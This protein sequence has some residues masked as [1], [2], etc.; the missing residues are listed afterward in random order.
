MN[1]VLSFRDKLLL[2]MPEEVDF[3]LNFGICLPVPPKESGELFLSPKIAIF[4]K[5]RLGR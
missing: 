1:P 4:Q 2:F 5:E 3:I